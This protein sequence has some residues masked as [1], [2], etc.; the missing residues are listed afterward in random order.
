MIQR[1]SLVLLLCLSGTCVYSQ[2]YNVCGDVS[3]VDRHN[4]DIVCRNCLI[5]LDDTL[6]TKTDNNGFFK[7][8]D[9][10]NGKHKL[11]IQTPTCTRQYDVLLEDCDYYKSYFLHYNHDDFLDQAKLNIKNNT[12]VIYELGG[13]APVS[14]PGPYGFKSFQS[15]FGTK[16][17]VVGCEIETD[18][19]TYIECNF[20]AFDWL[21]SK[22]GSV[23]RT[24]LWRDMLRHI[25]GFD[26]WEK[27]HPIP[28]PDRIAVNYDDISLNDN[29]LLVIDGVPIVDQD[30]SIPFSVDS[31]ETYLQRICPIIQTNDIEDITLSPFPPSF[32][33]TGRFLVVTTK[34]NS[35]IDT[36]LL[37]GEI[38]KRPNRVSI[39]NFVGKCP[40]F[41]YLE[42]K[43]KLNKIES[44]KIH[45]KG[46]VVF[47]DQNKKSTIFVEVETK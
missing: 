34:P 23:W 28:L 29:I 7:F 5:L 43:W 22:W 25:A 39:K 16:V 27:A 4:N 30:K 13:I 33:K 38:S 46:K 44:V 36:I 11:S 15:W 17:E 2:T 1:I 8:T 45:K 41:Y 26:E 32:C 42:K 12:P 35:G 21:L 37:N 10:P 47:D 9:I 24:G 14:I 3:A 18:D 20:L 19:E 6:Q 31:V 40:D